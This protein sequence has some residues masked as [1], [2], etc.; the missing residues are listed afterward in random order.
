[1]AVVAHSDPRWTEFV[2]GC[3]PALLFHHLSWARLLAASSGYRHFAL[4]LLE[5]NGDISAGGP[6]LEVIGPLGRRRCLSLAF[7]NYCRLLSKNMPIE[8]FP[9]RVVDEDRLSGAESLELRA[10]LSGQWHVFTHTN[11]VCQ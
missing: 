11:A 5:A 2:R 3:S 1:M 6:V 8:E 4:F 9:S 7:P 10:E